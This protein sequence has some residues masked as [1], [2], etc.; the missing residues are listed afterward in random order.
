MLGLNEEIATE[1][2]ARL[3]ERTI[4]DEPFA[5]AHAYG[6]GHGR[7]VEWVGGQILAARFDLVRE[8][9]GFCVTGLPLTLTQGLL[10]NINQQHVFHSSASP[11]QI[12]QG[13]LR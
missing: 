8:P 7:R 13:V 9:R 4:R 10:V 12:G 6:G 3:C 1:L 11:M 2:L 5:V